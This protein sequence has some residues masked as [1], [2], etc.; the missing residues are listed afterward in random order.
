M[1][2][3]TVID[4]K[5]LLKVARQVFLEKGAAATTAEVAKRAGIAQGSI[6]KRHKTKQ[7]LFRAAMQ[8]EEFPWMGTLEKQAPKNLQKA[9]E[10][11]GHEII[12]FGRNAVPMMMMTWSNRGSFGPFEESRATNQ[13]PPA[14]ESVVRFFASQMR[15][16]R[17]RK[18]NPRVLA[19][20][21]FGGFMHYALIEILRRGHP[22]P[23]K[24]YVRG[25]VQ[26]LWAGVAPE[27]K[28]S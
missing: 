18:I 12:G 24:E 23:E 26:I 28:S 17:L 13:L 8:S 21:Y 10:K 4:D 19:T 14:G 25:F 11:V 1:A 15:A 2:R 9:L 3:P 7:E 22:I 16:G 27:R 20:A 5:W 6:F